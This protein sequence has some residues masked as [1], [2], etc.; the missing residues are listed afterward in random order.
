MLGG[1]GKLAAEG[2]AHRTEKATE[3]AVHAVEGVVKEVVEHAK[4]A[5]EK[6]QA[7]QVSEA[8]ESK[9]L[10]WNIYHCPAKSAPC[11]LVGFLL[12]FEFVPSKPTLKRM[13][14]LSMVVKTGTPSLNGSPLPDFI[15]QLPCSLKRGSTEFLQ[16]LI[17]REWSLFDLTPRKTPLQGCPD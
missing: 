16:S 12:T 2:L 10:T 3:E 6:E 17:L 7:S 8:Q 13:R 1:L 9:V 11:I 15:L 14:A 5:G 4:E